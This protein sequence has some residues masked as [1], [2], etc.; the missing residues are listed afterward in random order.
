MS[1]EKG[2]NRKL[3]LTEEDDREDS[4]NALSRWN[5][6]KNRDYKNDEGR[7]QRKSVRKRKAKVFEGFEVS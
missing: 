1:T 7:G 6:R 3:R 5:E 2:V 4:F